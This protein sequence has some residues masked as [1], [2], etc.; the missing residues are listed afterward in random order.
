MLNRATRRKAENG[1]CSAKVPSPRLGGLLQIL[2]MQLRYVSKQE[3]IQA[4]PVCML[5]DFGIE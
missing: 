4:A 5:V 2:M 1:C 3:S